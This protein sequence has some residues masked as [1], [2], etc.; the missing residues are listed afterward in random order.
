M[1]Y[2]VVAATALIVSTSTVV[3][4]NNTKSAPRDPMPSPNAVLRF[5]E[6]LMKLRNGQEYERGLSE[7]YNNGYQN[8]HNEGFLETYENLTGELPG[9]VGGSSNPLSGGVSDLQDDWAMSPKM[10]DVDTE[11][12][13]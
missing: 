3:L 4:A 9:P 7:G 13:E 1:K 12:S 11:N 5:G 8:G 2:L 10:Q 6:E